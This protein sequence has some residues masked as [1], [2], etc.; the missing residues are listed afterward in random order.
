MAEKYI[1]VALAGIAAERILTGRKIKA[2][3][4]QDGL[5][6]WYYM[7]QLVYEEDE[8]KA[9]SEWLLARA[10]N[11]LRLQANW[12]AVETLANKLLMEKYIG[13]K[14]AHE[15]IRAAWKDSVPQF[16]NPPEE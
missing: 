14:R 5:T 4:Y 8:V 10:E 16:K 9:Y 11:L 15:I 2:G 7:D 3:S 6:A 12:F 13:S 1:L